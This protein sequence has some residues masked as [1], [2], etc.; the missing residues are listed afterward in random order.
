M[1][2][3]VRIQAWARIVIAKKL[4]REKRQEL[5]RQRYLYEESLKRQQ[6]K[7][8]K[9]NYY[10]QS[11]LNVNE[12]EVFSQSSSPDR[13]KNSKKLEYRLDTEVFYSLKDPQQLT[14]N[15]VTSSVF[16]SRKGIHKSALPK[17]A[18]KPQKTQDLHFSQAVD[19]E[20]AQK[21]FKTEG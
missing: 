17:S 7:A 18:L 3:A 8:E 2:A 5:Q 14:Q 21:T 16:N 1:R 10:R 6:Q 20:A 4:A 13:A 15:S 11:T 9:D 19:H 12:E